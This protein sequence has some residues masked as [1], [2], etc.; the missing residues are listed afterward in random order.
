VLSRVPRGGAVDGLQDGVDEPERVLGELAA[1]GVRAVKTC[2]TGHGGALVETRLRLD[3]AARALLRL[4][5]HA[6]ER[7]VVRNEEGRGLRHRLQC[8]QLWRRL[9]R[10][11]RAAE[12]QRAAHAAGPL[13]AGGV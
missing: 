7:G 9:Q 11:L 5:G 4:R 1:H 6:D 8:W 2:T 13:N 12:R 10:E 3:E